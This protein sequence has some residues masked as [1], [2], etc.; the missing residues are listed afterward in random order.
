MTKLLE[1]V[2]A[3]VRTLAQDEQDRAA[4]AL[5][6]FLREREEYAQLA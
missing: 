6:L 3:D 5:L 4:Q 1:A 2:V